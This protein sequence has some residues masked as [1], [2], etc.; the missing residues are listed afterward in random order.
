MGFSS[1][2]LGLD[3]GTD[4]SDINGR[5]DT[6]DN[7]LGAFILK[8]A[9]NEG[10]TIFDMID[11][12]ADEYEDQSGVDTVTSTSIYNATSDYYVGG[13][14]VSASTPFNSGNEN[15]NATTP[16]VITASSEASGTFAGWK[17]YDTSG[18]S[19]WSS[20][21]AAAPRWLKIDLGS[22]NGMTFNGYRFKGSTTDNDPTDWT[23]E[24]SNNDSDW[25][26]L[27]TVTGANTSGIYTTVY[28]MDTTGEYRYYRIVTTL[29]QG[30]NAGAAIFD[31]DWRLAEIT[32][33]NGNF[34]HQSQAFTA[35]S[36][37]SY[38]RLVILHEPVDSVTINTD[39]KAY[40]SRDGGT[41][42][43]LATLT[44][45]GDYDATTQILTT[46]DMDISG[47]PSGTSVLY[48]IETANTKEQ[49]VHAAWTQ[50]R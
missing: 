50:W 4:L 7:R 35:S 38:S 36:E 30:T 23:I 19:V 29:S 6:V 18:T 26:T 5:I 2:T 49:R 22:G 37:P 28:T 24:G 25:D 34:L 46:G 9:I 39:V 27:H 44:D 33:G 42:W 40:A 12:R 8:V 43:T 3:D 16:Y 45:D 48:K 17:A 14:I 32:E 11:G 15:T 31:F 41:T 20:G 1:D 10:W 47:Q 21:A 13:V